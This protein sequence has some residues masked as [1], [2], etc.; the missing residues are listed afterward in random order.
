MFVRG[1]VG[2][3]SILKRNLILCLCANGKDTKLSRKNMAQK[4]K[5]KKQK[6]NN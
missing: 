5:L 4:R 2:L 1:T 6:S 3:R